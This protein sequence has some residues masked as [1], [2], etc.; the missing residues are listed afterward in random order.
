MKEMNGSGKFSANAED[1]VSQA[2]SAN[3]KNRTSIHT[4]QQAINGISQLSFG[5]E[6]SISLKKPVSILEVAKQCE[7]SGILQEPDTKDKKQISSAK[8]KELSEND[9]FGPPPEIAPHSFT[10][11]RTLE[12]KGYKD[13]GGFESWNVH[14]SEKVSN[15]S[16]FLA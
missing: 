14:T 15:V 1:T 3:S 11:A 6:E 8:T 10:T 7:L 9:I 13:T 5:T 4:Y 16:V 12:S 2:N